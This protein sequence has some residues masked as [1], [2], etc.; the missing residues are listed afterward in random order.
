MF[1]SDRPLVDGP[2]CPLCDSQWMNEQQLREHL[3]EKLAKS[4]EARELQETLLKNGAA[5]AR[6][7]IRVASLLV[8]VQKMAE[9]Q[10]ENAFSQILAAWK[11]NLETFKADLGTIDGL[12]GLK[13]RLAASWV[14]TPPSF[15]R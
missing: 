14:E 7:A 12:T 4:E 10:G 2:E 11:A 15:P 8:A 5:V 6:E 1:L 13:D 9:M 3:K